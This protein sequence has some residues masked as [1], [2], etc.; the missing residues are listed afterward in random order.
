MAA[1]ETSA[2]P[3]VALALLA[4]VALLAL[5]GFDHEKFTY[6]HAGRDFRLTDLHGKVV[7]GIM[8]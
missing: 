2:D 7:R 5:L 1:F 8:A 4:K 6:H 3:A